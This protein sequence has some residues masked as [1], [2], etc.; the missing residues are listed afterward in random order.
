LYVATATLTA[1]PGYTF[2][3]LAADSFT[4]VGATSVVTGVNGKVTITF[5]A[6]DKAWYVSSAGDDD[7]GGTNA[8]GDALL[9]VTEALRLINIDHK[10]GSPLTGAT[11]VVIGTSGDTKT[12]TI[13]DGGAADNYPPITLRGMS[14]AKPGIL[15][16]DKGGWETA[17]YRVLY[18][19]SG[20]RVTLGNDLTITR[21]GKRDDVNYGGGVNIS[22]NST[23]TMNGGTI[24]DNASSYQG[25]ALYV[26]YDSAFI[27]NGGIISHNSSPRTGGVAVNTNSKFTMNGG[28]ITNNTST[29]S[30]SGVQIGGGAFDMTGGTISANISDSEGGGVFVNDNAAFTMSGGV[31]SGNTTPESGGG[32]RVH[33]GGAFTM[34]GGTIAN[35]TAGE[36]GDG[37][38][39]TPTAGSFTMW[40]GI[41]SGNTAGTTGGGVAVD[42]GTFKK[43]PAG[44][45]QTS[46]IIYGNDGSAN[47][48]KATLGETSLNNDKGHAVYVSDAIRRETTVLPDQHLGSIAADE[49]PALAR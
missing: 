11:I 23:F 31:I 39:L 12:I 14:P 3:G 34:K 5:P 19:V 41:I 24:T 18:I 44:T 47:R 9:T 17:T 29:Y 37:V 32:V 4:Y 7:H 21:G 28:T 33:S 26:R 10:D 36:N 40:G 2:A 49:P 6:L 38:H 30:G 25:G 15:T 20:G 43:E 46:G 27:M 16:A 8:D 13:D 45:S 22:T 35:N 48:N 42:G 1:N